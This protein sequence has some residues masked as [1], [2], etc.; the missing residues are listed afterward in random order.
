MPP[1]TRPRGKAAAQAAAAA[2]AAPMNLTI[3]L[4]GGEQDLQNVAYIAKL[5]EA[6][7]LVSNHHNFNG[8][9]TPLTLG[10]GGSQVP[11]KHSHYLLALGSRN[12]FLGEVTRPIS[13]IGDKTNISHHRYTGSGIP[14]VNA[15][16]SVVRNRVGSQHVNIEQ[17]CVESAWFDSSPACDFRVTEAPKYRWGL[18]VLVP[19][20]PKKMFIQ[21]PRLKYID[22]VTDTLHASSSDLITWNTL[23][24]RGMECKGSVIP[25]PR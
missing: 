1:K 8:V 21:G 23:V 24:I 11:Y 17:W 18:P 19:T 6:W 10:Q 9:S 25:V 12:F 13:C 16:H 15:F 5:T 2:P 22:I 14:P 20:C 7:T 3:Q 4:Q